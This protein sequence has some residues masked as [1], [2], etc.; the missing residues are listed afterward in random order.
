M[1]A[2][3]TKPPHDLILGKNSRHLKPLV[4]R[5]TESDDFMDEADIPQMVAITTR[6]QAKEEASEEDLHEFTDIDIF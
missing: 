1:A 2:A 6:N 4:H 3:T 5:K